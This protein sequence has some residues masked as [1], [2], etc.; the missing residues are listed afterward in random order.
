M[1]SSVVVA[2][3]TNKCS[4]SSAHVNTNTTLTLLPKYFSRDLK[5]AF[6]MGD[7][8]KTDRAIRVTRC[9]CAGGTLAPRP[10]GELHLEWKAMKQVCLTSP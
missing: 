2:F 9:G 3:S 10:F 4:P 7:P 8:S 6:Q 1:R 5:S